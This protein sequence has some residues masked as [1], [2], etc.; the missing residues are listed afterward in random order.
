AHAGSME[1]LLRA[2]AE[3]LAEIHG[4]GPRIAA[5]VVHFFAQ[6]ENVRVVERLKAAGVKMEEAVAAGPK[7]LAGKTFVLTGTLSS[8]SR[9]SAR[10]LITRLGGRVTSAVSKKTDYVVAGK[11]AGSKLEEARRL[12][13]ATLD[14][15]AFL[16]LVGKG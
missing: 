7:P 10:D 16:A 9:D 5:G 4:V 13:V 2:S 15:A 3:E 6:E 14:E 12:G 8:M 1:R 11:E